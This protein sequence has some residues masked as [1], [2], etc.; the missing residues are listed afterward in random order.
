[1][2]LTEFTFFLPNNGLTAEGFDE[3]LR[4]NDMR[5]SLFER[6]DVILTKY[7]L[8]RSVSDFS[9]KTQKKEHPIDFLTINTV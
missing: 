4:K 1:M 2:V 3:K 9:L 6:M 5:D 8:E 7:G